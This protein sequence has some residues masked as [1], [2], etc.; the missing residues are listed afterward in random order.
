MRNSDNINKNTKQKI[1]QQNQPQNEAS[2][3]N[4]RD[5]LMK[6]N[7]IV[8]IVLLAKVV[9]VLNVLWSE[10]VYIDCVIFNRWTLEN[11]V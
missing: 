5:E 8:S 11:Y 6:E 1:K 3:A 7:N 2:S 10:F 9:I 4:K